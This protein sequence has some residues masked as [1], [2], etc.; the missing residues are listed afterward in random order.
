MTVIV[1]W[2]L[3]GRRRVASGNSRR[4]TT[5]LT[6]VNPAFSAAHCT[7]AARCGPVITASCPAGLSAAAACATQPPVNS[8]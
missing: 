8:R 2:A 1:Q 4:A 6:Q 5:E 3:A 7:T